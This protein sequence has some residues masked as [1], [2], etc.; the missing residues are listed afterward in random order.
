[1][2]ME[3]FSLSLWTQGL[4][5][6]FCPDFVQLSCCFIDE[7]QMMSQEEETKIP[8]VNILCT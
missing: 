3:I 6:V 7:S 4:L 1:M 5:K 8:G 2:I